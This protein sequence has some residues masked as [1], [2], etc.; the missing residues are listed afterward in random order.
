[1]NDKTHHRNRTNTPDVSALAG[2]TTALDGAKCYLST[3]R[4]A[5]L[6]ALQATL[7]PVEAIRKQLDALAPI[8]GINA[9][10]KQEKVIGVSLS[11]MRVGDFAAL[12]AAMR[13]VESIRRQLD[14]LAS[15]STRGI[16]AAMKQHQIIDGPLSEMRVAELA[17]LKVAMRPTEAIRRQ[18]DALG[19]T[20]GIQAAMEQHQV[21]SARLS[22]L[23]AVESSA[24]GQL[25]KFAGN[26]SSAA[27]FVALAPALFART[28]AIEE[29]FS[30]SKLA[31]KYIEELTANRALQLAANQ[32]TRWR[33]HHSEL[34]G[35]FERFQEPLSV[36]SAR[37]FLESMAKASE[38]FGARRL[39]EDASQL[40]ASDEA[41]ED[42][43][44]LVRGIT[45]G[46]SNA[47]TAQEAVDQIVQAIQ[48]TKEPLH[49]K[50]LY[51]ILVPLLIAI[52]F[53]FVNPIADSYVKKWMEGASKQGTPKQE[54]TKQVRAIAR[55]AV[56]DVRLLNSF[57]FVSAQSLALKSGPRANARVVGQL[58]FGQLVR[59]LEKERN[60]TLVVWSSEDGEVELQGWVFSR[61]LKRF[62]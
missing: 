3:N 27:R 20:S 11:A 13:P 43:A 49:Q 12:Q 46:V 51:I 48:A 39:L 47:L 32:A 19:P 62:K 7:R 29:M 10:I 52:V 31:A 14:A 50:L 59:V 57:R 54:A 24:L 8:R 17:A 56:G 60:F 38:P 23:R 55:E 6:A 36:S 33:V 2:N 37:A 15:T 25:R 53:A 40:S 35:A 41:R 26:S 1:M 18:L 42:A 34:I 22:A 61:Y 28:K 21:A 16:Q 45:E 44:N 9:A 58:M 4:V 30:P 5:E